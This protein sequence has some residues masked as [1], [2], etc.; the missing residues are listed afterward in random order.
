[1]TCTPAVIP[2]T[3]VNSLPR[4]SLRRKLVRSTRSECNLS[5]TDSGCRPHSWFHCADLKPIQVV[6][7]L[8]RGRSHRQIYLRLRAVLKWFS[9]LCIPFS[10]QA[11]HIGC[12]LKA[13]GRSRLNPTGGPQNVTGDPR[14]A[15]VSLNAGASWAA[16]GPNPAIEVTTVS[17]A[18]PEPASKA[19]LTLGL[20]VV[21]FRRAA[22]SRRAGFGRSSDHV[23]GRRGYFTVLKS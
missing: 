10:A 14:A 20:L 21:M 2:C 11:A 4:N 16:A 13:Q 7:L 9:R 19:L 3:R 15:A 18:I 23:P 17:T 12:V 1:M 8:S 5:G 22:L 6:Q